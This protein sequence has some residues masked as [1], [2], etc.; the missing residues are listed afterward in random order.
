MEG[1][2]ISGEYVVLRRK[3][4]VEMVIVFWYKKEGFGMCDGE[5]VVLR[6]KGMRKWVGVYYFSNTQR[7]SCSCFTAAF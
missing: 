5:F 7:K 3:G 4:H 1:I 6:R 2:K